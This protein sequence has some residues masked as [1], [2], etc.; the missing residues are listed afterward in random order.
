MD[1]PTPLSAPRGSH[2]EHLVAD[3]GILDQ[4]AS[5]PNTRGVASLLERTDKLLDWL[6]PTPEAHRR[7]MA[8]FQFI[9]S[10]VSDCFGPGAKT[11]LIGSCALKTYL[12][13]ADIDMSVFVP[14][15][16]N[17]AADPVA[18][19][20]AHICK[21]MQE[22]Q[23]ARA[24]SR[25]S[26]ATPKK[27]HHRHG[28][29]RRQPPLHFHSVTCISADT[30][31]IKCIVDNMSVDITF[32]QE[33]AVASLEL[34]ERFD[35]SYIGQNHILKKSILLLKAWLLHDATRAAGEDTAP[36]ASSS[37][38]AAP[39]SRR[40]PCHGRPPPIYGAKDGGLCTYALN[41]MVTCL[42][43][44]HDVR[45]PFQAFILFFKVFADFDWD[46]F[47]VTLFG[48]VPLRSRDPMQF[49]GGSPNKASPGQSLKM[50]VQQVACF[51]D[52]AIRSINIQD[53]LLATNNLG[54][55]VSSASACRFRRALAHG[56]RNLC[57]ALSRSVNL[58]D[59]PS[60]IQIFDSI[61]ASCFS[62]FGSG[63]GWRP[64]L[65]DHPMQKWRGPAHGVRQPN[66]G[67][68]DMTSM[69]LI[70]S[71]R[72]ELQVFIDR[73]STI[74]RERGAAGDQTPPRLKPTDE[75]SPPSTSSTGQEDSDEDSAME[76]TPVRTVEAG[77]KSLEDEAG[78]DSASIIPCPESTNDNAK[79]APND[80]AIGESK[81]STSG[82]TPSVS[83]P[84]DGQ[85][86]S[87]TAVA[88][89][90]PESGKLKDISRDGMSMCRVVL[91]AIFAF[92][93]GGASLAILLSLSNNMG[94]LNGIM[95]SPVKSG[96]GPAGDGT[97]KHTLFGSTAS[98]HF[99]YEDNGSAR[100]SGSQTV[101]EVSR[102]A[103]HTD[104][105]LVPDASTRADG[106]RTSQ[107]STSTAGQRNQVDSADVEPL[108]PVVQRDILSI[109]GSTISL[110]TALRHAPFYYYDFG[111][112][113]DP[114]TT[115][116]TCHEAGSESPSAQL[117]CTDSGD[118]LRRKP[119][120]ITSL[121]VVDP[122]ATLTLSVAS[123]SR[124][125]CP[126]GPGR[127]QLQSVLW[128]VGDSLVQKSN[129]TFLTLRNIGA[130]RGPA[131]P[132]A[133][134]N[135]HDIFSGAALGAPEKGS[136]DG[137]LVTSYVSCVDRND[138][139]SLSAL[140][141]FLGLRIRVQISEDPV[142]HN[143]VGRASG[144]VGQRL[145]LEGPLW[146]GGAGADNG[147]SKLAEP[148]AMQWSRNGVDLEGE[149]GS[150]WCGMCSTGCAA[151]A[152]NF[153]TV[154]FSD[155]LCLIR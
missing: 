18:S 41:T 2:L 131:A 107:S 79:S 72:T 68:F 132:F 16:Y 4:F 65:L 48:F 69:E 76:P 47:Y 91:V 128:Y 3:A 29:P 1:V 84:H 136:R 122:G 62:Q 155:L 22:Q 125:A 83:L 104:S 55:S 142:L 13:D 121:L 141:T 89:P 95:R 40:G 39:G 150:S 99:N 82:E 10:V 63:D 86:G 38:R 153:I 19:L 96:I 75:S 92:A 43:N 66:I 56:R 143:R 42:L 23:A 120:H 15:S 109:H 77:K 59:I 34:F 113:S 97:L 33:N 108:P 67:E 21:A 81:Q 5:L 115:A 101:P 87:V 73:A 80:N 8:V 31:V 152:D 116:L 140:S 110:Q 106:A 146:H 71:I 25:L 9:R 114:A 117:A 127:Q 49:L 105:G 52:R 144:R 36:V 102:P 126:A 70:T 11:V 130:F 37:A 45:H 147:A 88:I 135:S 133:R 154:W 32:G 26:S 93:L 64:D 50:G 12:P 35:A 61:F 60:M 74:K 137:A 57:V 148:Y 58:A 119:R 112:E 78:Y 139:Q 118:V 30:C 134:V 124:R 145:V 129:R 27:Q 94:M 46:R 51:P 103:V 151:Q 149:T 85:L 17:Q 28:D 123:E 20:T 7:R 53:P 90:S 6:A 14:R 138:D 24:A 111:G 98:S 54:R 100:P 44:T